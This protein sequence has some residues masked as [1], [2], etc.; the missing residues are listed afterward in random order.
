M[1]D[2]HSRDKQLL[3]QVEQ[4]LTEGQASGDSLLD[5][6]AA[7]QPQPSA[8]FQNT[9]EE[10]LMLTAHD[11][12]NNMQ[13]DTMIEP[14]MTLTPKRRWL[15][16]LPLTLAAAI[17]ITFIGGTALLFMN[18][19]GNSTLGFVAQAE[20]QTPTLVP[21]L[22]PVFLT[23]TSIIDEA[24]RRAGDDIDPLAMTATAILEQMP[25]DPL[26]LTAT[27]IIDES[28][29]RALPPAAITATALIG[30]ATQTA[31]AAWTATALANTAE[32]EPVIATVTAIVAQATA[33]AVAEASSREAESN[34]QPILIARD[35]IRRGTQITAEMLTTIYAPSD[36]DFHLL[37]AERTD[38][39][40]DVVSA[41][42]GSEQEAAG[43]YAM[44]DIPALSPLLASDLVAEN[45]IGTL[46]RGLSYPMEIKI[47]MSLADSLT[48]GDRAR[49][50]SD[51]SGLLHG[52]NADEPRWVTVADEVEVLEIQPPDAG[53]TVVS[54][55]MASN[56]ER[57]VLMDLLDRGMPLRLTNAEYTIPVFRR[58]IITPMPPTPLTSNVLSDYEDWQMTLNENTRMVEVFIPLT[59]VPNNL[60]IGDNV[61]I[62]AEM[63]FSETNNQ[64]RI[65]VMAPEPQSSY[66]L[67]RGIAQPELIRVETD[68]LVVS[69]SELEAVELSR[70]LDARLP[71][72]L[73]SP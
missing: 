53:R 40:G 13:E 54:V 22:E 34:L 8:D 61:G 64:T 62:S 7:T 25:V 71:L 48:P 41:F 59:Q 28:T 58:D 5:A 66:R 11:L 4:A 17:A 30:Q 46:P 50:I 72:T 55:T 57:L 45:P 9:L 21:S 23:G 15:N 43:Q 68:G 10:R 44:V 47:P 73:T 1:T 38:M 29:Q 24:T 51:F 52:F 39:A 36:L 31:D 18:N 16:R 56:N 20:T 42:D 65:E 27:A 2:N 14:E 3:E 67:Y 12:K 35:T 33:S 19:G 32:V 26:S 69:M 70:A 49:I 63:Q 6:L 37:E 60:I